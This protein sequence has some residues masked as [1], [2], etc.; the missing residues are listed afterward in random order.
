MPYARFGAEG[1]PEYSKGRARCPQRA[2][3]MV[4]RHR[5]SYRTGHLAARWGLRALPLPRSWRSIAAFTLIELLVVIA[6]IAILA[7]MLLPALARSKEKAKRATCA[8]N[9]HQLGLATLMYAS[10][11]NDLLPDL[12]NNGVWFWDMWKPAAS[13]LLENVKEN[14]H[15]L[16]PQRVLSL[17]GQR[18]R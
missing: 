18:Y 9:Q 16:L 7:A 10:D 1:F 17:Q 11:N 2:G 12:Q 14:R 6:I 5:N 8:N 3:R 4:N 15:F 13:N